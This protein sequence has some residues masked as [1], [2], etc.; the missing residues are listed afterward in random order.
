MPEASVV[1][2][3]LCAAASS[4]DPRRWIREALTAVSEETG[5]H[6]VVCVSDE[7]DVVG[8]VGIGNGALTHLRKMIR[9]AKTPSVLV[10]ADDN[11]RAGRVLDLPGGGWAIL[12]PKTASEPRKAT[13]AFLSVASGAVGLFKASIT[14]DLT[15]LLSRSAFER[16][17][18]RAIRR[19]K[20]PSDNERRMLSAGTPPVLILCDLDNFHAVNEKFGH[21]IGDEVLRQ[22]TRVIRSMVKSSDDVARLGRGDEIGILLVDV[23]DEE[24]GNAVAERIREALATDEG[25]R[26]ILGGDPLTASFGVAIWR[27]GMTSRDLFRKADE[28]LLAAKGGGRNRVVAAGTAA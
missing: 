1:E 3:A 12:S 14:D 19:A 28:A 15:G 25:I 16:S 20:P 13:L 18:E 23:I 2:K 27:V 7:Y 17:V 5:A 11:C 6:C 21:D 4:R 24:T 8:A 10:G 22:A 26:S 9:E